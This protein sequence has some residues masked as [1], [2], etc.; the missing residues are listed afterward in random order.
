MTVDRLLRFVL[1]DQLELVFVDQLRLLHAA[2]QCEDV[3]ADDEGQQNDAKAGKTDDDQD[4]RHGV[5]FCWL[6]RFSAKTSARIE[7]V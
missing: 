3:E 4:G 6:P 7:F 2:E 5:P 1:F